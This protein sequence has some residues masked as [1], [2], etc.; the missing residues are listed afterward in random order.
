[1]RNIQNI[2]V[3]NHSTR[4]LEWDVLC[5]QR[6]AALNAYRLD[7]NNQSL[8]E[9]MIEA[10]KKLLPYKDIF[11]KQNKINE[12]EGITQE[13]RL[14]DVNL[15]KE[16]N[17]NLISQYCNNTAL[18][19]HLIP[20]IIKHCIELESYKDILTHQDIAVNSKNK[21]IFTKLQ[22]LIDTV[23]PEIKKLIDFIP[24][25]YLAKCDSKN[26]KSYYDLLNKLNS[27][28][29][30]KQLQKVINLTLQYN[31]D[32]EKNHR[33]KLCEFINE[34]TIAKLNSIVSSAIFVITN[35]ADGLFIENLTYIAMSSN[36]N[37][38]FLQLQ[39]MIEALKYEMGP[40]APLVRFN[41]LKQAVNENKLAKVKG[42]IFSKPDHPEFFKNFLRDRIKFEEESLI[43]IKKDFELYGIISEQSEDLLKTFRDNIGNLKVLLEFSDIFPNAAFINNIAIGQHSNGIIRSTHLFI[44][45]VEIFNQI[46]QKSESIETLLQFYEQYSFSE[47][48]TR[49]TQNP[50]SPVSEVETV[51]NAMT[52]VMAIYNADISS[53]GLNEQSSSSEDIEYHSHGEEK[54]QS[55]VIN[56]TK[57]E[58]AKNSTLNGFKIG[59]KDITV[60]ISDEVEKAIKNETNIPKFRERFSIA[61]ERGIVSARGRTGIKALSEKGNIKLMEVKVLGN[62]QNGHVTIG[63]TRLLCLWNT[64]ENVMYGFSLQ[65]HQEVVK[66]VNAFNTNSEKFYAEVM[67]RIHPQETFAS[68]EKAKKVTSSKQWQK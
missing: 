43:K 56:S 17:N 37:L 12:F 19:Q 50:A 6:Q 36:D 23:Q 60:K 32:E 66:T 47:I 30:T 68:A 18:S 52:E 64:N 24:D 1:M 28:N 65:N 55:E 20:E 33:Y 49:L 22:H 13:A 44:Y 61:V 2:S 53:A 63:D 59:S 5:K 31:T 27:N 15:L 9:A 4:E 48:N 54:K 67:K 46:I 34:A 41:E 39:Y 57:K 3:I 51:E 40:N 11:I 10:S 29:F 8:L 25:A 35:A 45:D 16:K 62:M 42:I 14:R 7:P 21:E 58:I 38:R 26:P